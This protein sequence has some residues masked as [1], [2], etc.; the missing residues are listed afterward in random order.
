MLRVQTMRAA[1]PVHAKKHLLA[2]EEHAEVSVNF[3]KGTDTKF[4]RLLNFKQLECLTRRNN[5][6]LQRGKI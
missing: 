5:M 3:K 1:F 6:L 2:M 4:H